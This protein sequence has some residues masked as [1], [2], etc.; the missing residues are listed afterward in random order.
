MVII[1]ETLFSDRQLEQ[2]I[3]TTGD[4]SETVS[5]FKK[6]GGDEKICPF[7]DHQPTHGICWQKADKSRLDLPHGPR[8]Q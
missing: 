6:Y 8:I 2:T 3:D 1:N 5:A 4:I 7:F